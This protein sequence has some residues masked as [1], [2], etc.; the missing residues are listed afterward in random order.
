LKLQVIAEKTAINV[1]GYFFA[2]PCRIAEFYLFLLDLRVCY[3]KQ[4]IFM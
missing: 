4:C 1:S 3:V 2:S